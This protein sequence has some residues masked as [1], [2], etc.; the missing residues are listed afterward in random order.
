MALIGGREEGG[1]AIRE[2]ERGGKAKGGFY[3]GS[4]W[5]GGGTLG[6]THSA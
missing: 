5:Q 3:C 1:G 4:R 2:V 6:A